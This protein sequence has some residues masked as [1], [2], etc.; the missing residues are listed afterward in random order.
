MN[1]FEAE[2]T[3]CEEIE[4]KDRLAHGAVKNEGKRKKGRAKAKGAA[5]AK[6]K[7]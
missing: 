2:L 7:K 4:E 1:A 3:K 5:D 6:N